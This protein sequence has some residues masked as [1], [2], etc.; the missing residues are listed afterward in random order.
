M[1]EDN[2]YTSICLNYTPE[3]SDDSPVSETSDFDEFSYDWDPALGAPEE[4]LDT[5][6]TLDS[7]RSSAQK[8]RGILKSSSGDPFSTKAV[9]ETSGDFLN[10]CSSSRVSFHQGLG[11]PRKLQKTR[12]SE[13]G[14]RSSILQNRRSMISIISE[15]SKKSLVGGKS[16]NKSRKL[17]EGSVSSGTL[18]LPKGVV[19]NG[20]GIGFTHVP[21]AAQSQISISSSTNQSCLKCLALFSSWPISASR[22]VF[23][24]KKNIM[25]QTYGST[26]SVQTD[27]CMS[28][29]SLETPDGLGRQ[30]ESKKKENTVNN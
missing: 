1:D 27:A 5:G 22:S 8:V 24:T 15:M 23:K 11:R 21:Q 4:K 3:E 29:V 13:A 6:Y 14:S 10:L 17:C 26:W 9:Y 2:L 25:Q 7:P 28:T 12:P 18:N 16:T 20:R 19:Q 30:V